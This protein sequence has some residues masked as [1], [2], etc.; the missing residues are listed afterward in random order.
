MNRVKITRRPVNGV[1]LLDKP[2]GATSNHAL[3]VAKRLLRAEKAGHTGT[4]DPLATGL[5]P[6]CFGEATKFSQTLLDAD[7][8]YEATIK[9]GERT[10]SGDAEGSVI[11]TRTPAVS[12]A[13]LEAALA[14]FQGEIEQIPPMHSALKHQG[15]PLYEYARRGETIERAARRVTIHHLQLIDFDGVIARVSV[16]CSKGTYIRA[17]ADDLG[18]AL[19]C[20]AHLQ[21]LRRTRIARFTIEQAIQLADF[22]ALDEAA[23][24]ARLGPVDALLE[25]MPRL[26]LSPLDAARIR[27]GQRLPRPDAAGGDVRLYEGPQFLGVGR[28][29][30]GVL[31]PLRLAAS[32]ASESARVTTT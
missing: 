4:L 10:D 30:N 2:Q 18:E 13:Q 22:E 29:E 32:P 7:K 25:D 19:G 17:L 24:D 26:D 12:L 8:A 14:R 5:L 1:L 15:R 31:A 21:A 11:S 27:H 16:D 20:G 23:R 6:L 3:Q 28:I 9:L